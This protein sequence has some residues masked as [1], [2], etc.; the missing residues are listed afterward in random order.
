L[1][2][3]RCYLLDESERITSFVELQAFSD[4]EATAQARRHAQLLRKPFE[5]WRGKEMI[6]REK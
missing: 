1:R 4:E 5:L 2:L 3:Y 6:F